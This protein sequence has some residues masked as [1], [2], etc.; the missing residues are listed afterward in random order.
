MNLKKTA[1]GIEFGSTRIK[2]VLIDNQ[3]HIL[4]Q[5]NHEW[6]NK[7]ENGYW[8]YSLIDTKQGL[9]RAFK[10]LKEDYKNKYKKELITTGSIGISAMM[11]GYLVFDE[12]DKLLTPF[13][14]WRNVNAEEA[15]EKLTELFN[16]HIPA[17]WSI[18]H[19]Y[20]AILNH[21][22]HVSKIKFQTTLEGYIHY[23]LTNE[24]VIGIGEASGMF[25][26][27]INTKDYDERS[28]KLFDELLVS[29]KLPF[30]LRDIFPKVLVAGDNAGKLTKEGSLLLD[31]TGEFDYDIPLCPP[32][33]D[34][35]TGMIATNSIKPNT[36]NVSAGTSIFAIIVLEK[37]LKNV[38]PEID[39]VA[40][41]LGNMTAMVHAN[42]CSSEINTWVNLFDEVL[43]TFDKDVNKSELYEKL[44]KSSLD[45]EDDCDNLITINYQSG[46]PITKINSGRPI[47]TRTTDTNF[48]LANFMKSQIY[49]SFATMR[50]GIDILL[51]EGVVIK[52]TNAHG[53][54]FKT[55]G[56]AQ[57]YLAAAINAPVSV[58]ETAGEGGAWGMAL[59]ALYL[60][61][62]KSFQ[63][64]LDE[65]FKDS[66]KIVEQP[67]PKLVKGF[68]KYLD[69]YKKVLKAEKVLSEDL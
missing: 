19:L 22:E 50:L 31:P 52:G 2:A 58:I 26:I 32:E 43:K 47:V 56:V 55:Q 48:N 69:S 60:Q 34:A 36:G 51:S 44:F 23:L 14:T 20:Q 9:Q 30:K 15:S 66:K 16:Y 49:S 27:D 64:F 42:T 18:A 6:E 4:A 59:L 3:G 35:E 41:P 39:L 53:G 13:R 62:N 7:F 24:K 45:G 17:R 5:G 28:I 12:Y 67:D 68:N 46:E 21:E 33:G 10:N 63:D 65:I 37:N 38:Y 11:H 57:K 1:I 61:S 29:N 25:P 54:M 8:T 40:T